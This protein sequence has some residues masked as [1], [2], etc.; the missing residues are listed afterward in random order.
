MGTA[1]RK[2][3]ID[4][5]AELYAKPYEF[6]FTQAVRLLEQLHPAPEKLGVGPLSNLEALRIRSSI[7]LS[8]PPSDI[9][10]LHKDLFNS[11]RPTLTINFL[12]LAGQSGPLPNVYS[13]L[14]MS[15]VQHKDYAFKD[16]CDLFNHRLASI[17]YRIQVKYNLTLESE[18]PQH[19]MAAQVLEYLSGLIYRA[20]N[21]IHRIPRRS[22]LR[23]VGLLWQKPHSAMGLEALLK[24][25][26]QLSL[27]VK[28]FIGHWF[29]LQPSAATRI[30]THKDA[31]YNRLGSEAALGTKAW[32][33]QERIRIQIADL[34]L[35][36][37][38]DLL[39]GGALNADIAE[40]TRHYLGNENEFDF[41]LYL[42]AGE[43]PCTSLNGTAALGWSSWLVTG[44][45]GFTPEAIKVP[46]IEP[47]AGS[48]P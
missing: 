1:L 10:T 15:R 7:F 33:Q 29:V 12:G 48:N 39:P 46:A 43:A 42:K 11:S 14:I 20:E 45:S 36:T 47:L 35:A 17:H 32:I 4:I 30:G 2:Q 40:V 22:Y 37:F 34:D 44:Q 38:K 31:A 5:A 26:F 13:E 24:D 41:E 21:Y 25:F 9:Y 6:E 3:S 8:T 28:Q 16:F 23:Y 18:K 27:T 19:S